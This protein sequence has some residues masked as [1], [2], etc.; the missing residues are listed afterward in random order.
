MDEASTKSPTPTD[1]GG[2][3]ILK[4]FAYKNRG[5][6][7]IAALGIY[8]FLLALGTVGEIWDVEWILDLPLFRSPGKY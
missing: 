7:G 1:K 2:F 8:L 5:E 3:Q 4:D 6:L